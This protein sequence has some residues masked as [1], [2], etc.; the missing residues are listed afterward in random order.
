M[1]GPPVARIQIGSGEVL[2]LSDYSELSFDGRYFGPVSEAQLEEVVEPW[3]VWSAAK[4][5][6]GD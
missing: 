6:R 4:P 1:P 3:L 2:M 5:L